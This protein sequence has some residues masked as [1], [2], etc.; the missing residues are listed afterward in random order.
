[1][2]EGPFSVKLSLFKQSI[3]NLGPYQWKNVC[4]KKIMLFVA[5][6]IK[7]AILKNIFKRSNLYI[8][9]IYNSIYSIYT[10]IYI[11]IYYIIYKYI[12]I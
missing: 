3:Q 1:M 11:S 7:I 5:N 8:L 9:V 2:D 12:Y 4:L 6:L 10:Y